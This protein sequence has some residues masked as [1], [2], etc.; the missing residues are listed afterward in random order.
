MDTEGLLSGIA[1][2]IDDEID[3]KGATIN[4]LIRQI[5]QQHIPCLT[6]KTLPELQVVEHLGGVS[7]LLLDWLLMP[8][9]DPASRVKLPSTLQKENIKQN[10]DFLKALRATS[11]M[12]IFIFT[13]EDPDVVIKELESNGLYDEAHHNHILVKRKSDLEDSSLK[14]EKLLK[15][16]L[17]WIKSTPTIYLLRSW[18]KEYRRAR[19]ELFHYLYGLSPVWPS[20]MWRAFEKDG[21][22]GS[23]GLGEMISKN[24]HSRMAPFQLDESLL[25]TIKAVSQEELRG[26]LQGERFIPERYLH[27]GMVAC[28]DTFDHENILYLNIRPDC[29]CIPRK[30]GEIDE[31]SLYFLEGT[32][33]TASKEGKSFCHKYG[34]F[35]ERDN[36]AIVFSMYQGDTYTFSF[37]ELQITKVKDCKGKRIGRLL[38][39]FLNRI[40]Q[41]YSYYLQRQGLPRIPEDAV[42]APKVEKIECDS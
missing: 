7:L 30:S 15:E 22:N 28:G 35:P 33:V 20:I 31:I 19:T 39:P 11:F 3:S 27:K 13:N 4:N 21:V 17:E 24:L 2:V 18:N 12:P 9:V 38:H 37:K 10:I 25:E 14:N 1:V 32:K 23:L 41:R 6:F 8:N 26:V 5:K 29:D 16:V 40:Q 42:P 36:E 34:L